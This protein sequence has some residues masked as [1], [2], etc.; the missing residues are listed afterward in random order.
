MDPKRLH[1][2]DHTENSGDVLQDPDDGQM[3]FC[4]NSSQQA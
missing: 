3:L 1:E 4:N 2:Q